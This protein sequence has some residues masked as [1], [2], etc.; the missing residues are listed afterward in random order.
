M[1]YGAWMGMTRSGQT[2][3]S[4]SSSTTLADGGVDKDGASIMLSLDQDCRRPLKWESC[5]STLHQVQ[6]EQAHWLEAAFYMSRT[7]HLTSC[8]SGLS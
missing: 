3:C 2:S 8:L 4:S 5:R 1:Q 6:Q 7:R